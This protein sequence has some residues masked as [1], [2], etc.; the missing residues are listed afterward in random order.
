M[1][2]IPRFYAEIVNPSGISIRYGDVF[3]E[4]HKYHEQNLMDDEF[5]LASL[6]KFC[7]APV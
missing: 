2:S 6:H 4:I 3:P 1:S 7:D 5:V